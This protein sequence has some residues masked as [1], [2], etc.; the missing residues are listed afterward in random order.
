VDGADDGVCYRACNRYWN[1]ASDL[2]SARPR[3]TPEVPLGGL[4]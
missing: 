3:C 2:R 4:A 1:T